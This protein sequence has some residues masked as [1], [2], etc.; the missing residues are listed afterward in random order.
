MTILQKK[1]DTSKDVAEKKEASH[2][3]VEKV[4]NPFYIEAGIA[5]LNISITLGKLVKNNQY[6]SDLKGT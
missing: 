6:K 3:E 5:K 1:E 4:S 2:K